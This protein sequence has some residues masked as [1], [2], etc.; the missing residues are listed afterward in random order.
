[1]PLFFCIVVK[2]DRY[3]L[4]F[5][6]FLPFDKWSILHPSLCRCSLLFL[7]EAMTQLP[8][9][10]F[11]FLGLLNR[12]ETYSFTCMSWTY[13]FMSKTLYPLRELRAK[14]SGCRLIVSPSS[15]FL[16]PQ[17]STQQLLS[18]GCTISILCSQSLQ[19]GIIINSHL[20]EGRLPHQRMQWRFIA[21]ISEGLG[22]MYR[23][24]ERWKLCT[25]TTGF[26][27]APVWP[28]MSSEVDGKGNGWKMLRTVHE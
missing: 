16:T 15:L 26:W 1:M 27:V 3:Y 2:M 13:L 19:C 21:T 18:P 8:V 5:F 6:F 23:M 24:R 7:D 11:P 20:G 14:Q 17:S 12:F 22:E 28:C 25:Y 4:P 9:I 10:F